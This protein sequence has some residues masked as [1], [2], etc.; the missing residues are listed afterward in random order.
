MN[1]P[2]H[3]P[4]RHRATSRAHSAGLSLVELMVALTISLVLIAG[5]A[6][7]YV[8]SRNTYATSET[9]ARLQENARYAM[10]ILEPDIRMSGYWGLLKDA[11]TAVT[12]SALAT[13]TAS[14]ITVGNSCAT[15]F[16]VDLNDNLVGTNDSYPYTGNCAAWPGTDGKATALATADTLTIRRASTLQDTNTK[17]GRLRI[18]STRS[19]ATLVTDP[20]NDPTGVCALVSSGAA[21]MNDLIVNFYYVDTESSAGTTI[22]SL[23]RYS[24]TSDGTNTMS[25]EEVI[26]GIEDMQIQYGIDPTGGYGDTAGAATQYVN[27]DVANTLLS[28]K[29]SPA[30]VVAVRVWLLVRADVPEVGFTDTRSYDYGDRNHSNGYTA[31]LTSTADRT[32]AYRPGDST[33]TGLTGVQHYRR[34][35]ICKT[36]QLRNSL[37]T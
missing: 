20:A 14:A 17:A 9:A 22:P 3:G 6:Q 28:S 18:C 29:T 13:D 23:R 4:I 25:D 15:N 7:V 36:I 30:Q 35:L 19:A 34:M 1:Q 11:G 2:V 31:D 16:G 5:A 33:D 37:G 21:Q 27:A 12:N 26:T 32:K 10:S 24:L 8:N